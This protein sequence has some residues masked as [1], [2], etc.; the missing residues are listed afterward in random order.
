M[1]LPKTGT[2]Y[3]FISQHVGSPPGAPSRTGARSLAPI[4]L[5]INSKMRSIAR[6]NEGQ[7]TFAPNLRQMPEKNLLIYNTVSLSS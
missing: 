1:Q 3:S 4:C 2:I 5:P 7:V 6:G